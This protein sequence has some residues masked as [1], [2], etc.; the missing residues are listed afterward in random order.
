MDFYEYA[1]FLLYII[2]YISA[3]NQPITCVKVTHKHTESIQ[4]KSR[5]QS[6]HY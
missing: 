5:A 1:V 3:Q 6:W 4:S 2:F